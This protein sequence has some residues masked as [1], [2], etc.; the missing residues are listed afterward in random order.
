MAS[1][2][3][4]SF[5]SFSSDFS[6]SNGIYVHTSNETSP[7]NMWVLN[8][9]FLF[10]EAKVP[11]AV[12]MSTILLNRIENI[13]RYIMTFLWTWK[14]D[15]ECAALELIGHFLFNLP[16]LFSRSQQ[17]KSEWKN[18]FNWKEIM[19]FK[20]VCVCAVKTVANVLIAYDVFNNSKKKYQIDESR[21]SQ[22]RVGNLEIYSSQKRNSAHTAYITQHEFIQIDSNLA[23][24]IQTYLCV[25][26][27]CIG[28]IFQRV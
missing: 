5:D 24:F 14:K 15:S 28:I 11:I 21:G 20:C 25:A 1:T 27:L 7:S 26:L 17:P 23:C 3:I 19:A 2:V 13:L 18:A 8:R 9:Y 12:N 22:Y 16:S 10:A 6:S 4:I